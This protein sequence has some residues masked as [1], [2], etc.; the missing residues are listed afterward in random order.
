M[1]TTVK[2]VNYGLLSRALKQ[3]GFT[4]T[5]TDTGRT[6]RHASGALLP[7]PLLPDSEPVRAYH[8]AAARLTVNDYGILDARDFDLLLLRLSHGDR[9]GVS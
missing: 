9:A 8:L 5:I 4:E 6:F 7:Y 3:Q 2:E 1:I